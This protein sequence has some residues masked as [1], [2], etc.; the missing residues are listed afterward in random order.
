MIQ[1]TWLP[2]PCLAMDV[3]SDSAIPAFRWHATV[4][5]SH[6]Q[7]GL[8]S[9]LFPS[10]IPTKTIYAFLPLLTSVTCLAHIITLDSGENLN[11]WIT[12]LCSSR[13]EIN[14]SLLLMYRASCFQMYSVYLLSLELLI[15]VNWLIRKKCIISS[16]FVT[17]SDLLY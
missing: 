16:N 9:G 6:L 5:S 2:S 17:M 11:L 10:D 7:I 14:F 4:L 3:R 15:K 12:S 1:E 13:Y 8:P